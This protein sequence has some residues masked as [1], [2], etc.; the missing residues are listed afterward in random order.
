MLYIIKENRTYDQVLGDM[1]D[2]SG[3]HIGNGEPKIAMFGDK[4][5]P[6]QHQIA[7]DY[8]LFDNLYCN[9][10]VSVDGHAWCDYGIANDFKQREW[11]V[12]YTAHGHLPGNGETNET[13]AGSIWDDCKRSSISFLCY[14]EGSWAV[15]TA[16]RGTW[17]EKG[18][19]K[20]RV[21]SSGLGI[22]Q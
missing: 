1:T 12:H 13:L 9:S 4:I 5:T 14:H 8:V 6:N 22:S 15:P 18:R 3:K 21:D 7:R 11:I 17:E 20:D 10:E 16:N 2:A 19:D